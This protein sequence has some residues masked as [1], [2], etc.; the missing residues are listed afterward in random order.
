MM[1]RRTVSESATRFR[2]DAPGK[3]PEGRD[4]PSPH[5][6]F[7]A[8]ARLVSLLPSYAKDKI[9]EGTSGGKTGRPTIWPGMLREGLVQPDEGL[10]ADLANGPL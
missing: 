3:T 8:A 9:N 7:V 4:D 6:A 5:F 1:G 10:L 2:H